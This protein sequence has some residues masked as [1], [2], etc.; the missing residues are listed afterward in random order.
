[1]ELI[2]GGCIGSGTVLG[3]L[4]G[5]GEDISWFAGGFVAVA[6][7]LASVTCSVPST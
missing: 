5:E 2:S 7:V 6:A 3:V 4:A 1:M